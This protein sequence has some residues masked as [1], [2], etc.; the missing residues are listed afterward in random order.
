MQVGRKQIT[1]HRRLFLFL[2]NGAQSLKSLFLFLCKRIRYHAFHHPRPRIASRGKLP[3]WAVFLVG[4]GDDDRTCHNFHQKTCI[5][6]TNAAKLLATLW[7]MKRA[8]CLRQK[9]VYT[10][11]RFWVSSSVVEHSALNR[12]VVGSIPTSPT[13]TIH[14]NPCIILKFCI[15][16]HSALL[17]KEIYFPIIRA[18]VGLVVHCLQ[19]MEKYTQAYV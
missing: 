16:M 12:L 2:G 18:V 6:M 14:A 7:P 5:H 13:M 1:D 11:I 4:S 10:K 3:G 15:K 19:T 17:Q 9:P 8:G